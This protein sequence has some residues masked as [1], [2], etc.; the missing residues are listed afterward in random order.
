MFDIAFW[1]LVLLALVG[2]LVLDSKRLLEVAAA[3][4]KSPANEQRSV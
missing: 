1:E 3:P 4:G 2:L